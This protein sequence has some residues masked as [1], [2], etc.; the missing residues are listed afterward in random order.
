M[1]S[2]APKRGL[3][4]PAARK[5][6]LPAHQSMRICCGSNIGSEMAHTPRSKD[7]DNVDQDQFL[8]I[9]SREDALARFEAAL[10]PRPVP[11][12]QPL[13]ARHGPWKQGGFE[14]RQRI[15]A[16][17]DGQELVLIDIVAIFRSGRMGHLRTYI[18]PAAYT[19][20][21]VCRQQILPRRRAPQATLR[22]GRSH[23][24]TAPPPPASSRPPA[25][26]LAARSRQYQRWTRSCAPAAN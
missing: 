13:L 14:A 4:C 18:T 21:L 9:L 17:Q 26:A 22:R 19:H 6:L 12:K 20:R 2:P 5:D 15:L 7:R 23:R 11:S 16:R 3:R 10:F 8:P 1:R 24:A 25:F